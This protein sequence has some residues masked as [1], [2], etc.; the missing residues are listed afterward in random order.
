M[1]V[2]SDRIF[3]IEDFL[4]D[5]TCDFLIKSFS[6]TLITAPEWTNGSGDYSGGASKGFW[7]EGVLE[8]QILFFY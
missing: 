7:K 6:D 3:V 8:G 5:E 2:L 4:S 1:K